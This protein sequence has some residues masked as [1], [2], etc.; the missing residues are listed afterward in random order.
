[1]GSETEVQAPPAESVAPAAA[2]SGGSKTGMILAIVVVLVVVVAALA[3][4]FVLDDGG[5]DELSGQWTLAGGS[6]NVKMTL[7]NETAT[8]I[9]MTD[10]FNASAEIIDFDAADV[11]VGDMSFVD[12]GNGHFRIMGFDELVD[13]IGDIEGTYDIDGDT[14]TVNID[15][16]ASYVDDDMGYVELEMDITWTL[17]RA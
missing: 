2:A 3:Y 6:F 16:N 15:E 5:G 17:E 9:E 8:T 14:M 4:V 7:N 10:T 1:M 11:E 12:L 13:G